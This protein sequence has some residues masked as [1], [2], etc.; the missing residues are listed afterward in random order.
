[1]GSRFQILPFFNRGP[2]SKTTLDV[3]AGADYVKKERM[4]NVYGT[5]KNLASPHKNQPPTFHSYWGSSLAN[6]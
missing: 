5:I 2:S 4:K 3:R 6:S 1:M